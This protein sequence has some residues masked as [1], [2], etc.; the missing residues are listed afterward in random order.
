VKFSAS[1][2]SCTVMPGRHSTSYLSVDSDHASAFGEL[3]RSPN[4][5]RISS[6]ITARL[7][8]SM[9]KLGPACR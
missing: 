5:A 8:F 6:A 1:S 7:L 4:A 2:K 9:K 3:H